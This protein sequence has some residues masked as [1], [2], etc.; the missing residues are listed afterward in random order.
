[1]SAIRGMRPMLPA[2]DFEISKRFYLD[3]GFQ[4][5]M[6]TDGLA[7]MHLGAFSFILQ[8]Y[9]VQQW[10]DNLVIHLFVSDVSL[11]WDHIVTLDIAS[12]YGVK[13]RAPQLESWG[14][15]VAGV[16]DPSGVLWR[17]HEVPA[18]TNS[19]NAP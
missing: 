19:E 12:H 3:L 1:A 17:I 9:Y 13:T 18:S 11:W 2:K 5:R 6:L 10:A 4:A 16:V 7:E 15:R 14:V 8:N